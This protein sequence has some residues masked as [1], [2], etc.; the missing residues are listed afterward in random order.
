MMDR[1]NQ[2]L[3]SQSNAIVSFHKVIGR[4]HQTDFNYVATA[5]IAS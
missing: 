1:M 2:V 4:E 3:E 5:T